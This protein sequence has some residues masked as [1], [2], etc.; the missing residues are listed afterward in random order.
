MKP[1]CYIPFAAACTFFGWFLPSLWLTE[2]AQRTAHRIAPAARTAP[3]PESFAADVRAAGSAMDQF[4]AIA[5]G[6]G[7]HAGILSAAGTLTDFSCEEADEL[8]ARLAG[9]ELGL[10]V[11]D[12][13]E[14]I[15]SLKKLNPRAQAS[16]LS[17]WAEH[18]PDAALRTLFTREGL[19]VA[20][21][22]DKELLRRLAE[23]DPDKVLQML[24]SAPP[25]GME[26]GWT[27]LVGAMTK[28]DPALALSTLESAPFSMRASAMFGLVSELAEK[29][30]Q[31]AFEWMKTLSP[32]LRRLVPV[33]VIYSKWG[34]RDPAAAVTARETKDKEG[35]NG[36]WSLTHKWAEKDPE[37]ALKWSFERENFYSV[38]EG[39]FALLEK[40]P[41]RVPSILDEVSDPQRIPTLNRIAAAWSTKDFPA[42][43]A[44]ARTLTKPGEKE[45]AFSNMVSA[46]NQ[47]PEAERRAFISEAGVNSAAGFQ[48]LWS[49]D[50][51][52]AI[53]N[54]ESMSAPQQ[55]E[56]W[57]KVS[58][59]LIQE[60]PAALAGMIDM[61]RKNDPAQKAVTAND[62]SD[63]LP[64]MISAWAQYDPAA[65]A[66]WVNTLP[67]GNAQTWAANNLVSS[68]SRN[69][70]E[71]AASWTRALP[72]GPAK[73]NALTQLAGATLAAGDPSVSLKWSASIK[74][75]D[76]RTDS[77][78]RNFATWFAADPSTAEATLNSLPVESGEKQSI[79]EFVKSKSKTP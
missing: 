27:A 34:D 38:S 76:I 29:D 20:G 66:A 15:R 42:V 32:D 69:D 4:Q 17:T 73:D 50:R 16:A 12:G 70:L 8:A 53:R 39:I 26:R 59:S 24:R 6:A 48:T 30:P 40:D 23:H 74:D 56:V 36:D 44:W 71:S 33:S 7:R 62:R 25:A 3:V 67:E 45:A 5:A 75:A 60:S 61:M 2:P 10:H 58:E 1:A 28:R 55:K 21:G 19:K 52:E 14:F 78:T 41:R 13:S 63:S 18:D 9:G 57:A 43:L 77:L 79:L 46:A 54:F 22:L 11:T 65:A 37:G 68:W 35:L 31:A 51:G 49:L 72:A 64:R 47:L